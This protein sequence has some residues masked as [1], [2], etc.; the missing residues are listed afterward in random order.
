VAV[1]QSLAAPRMVAVREDHFSSAYVRLHQPT[2][3]NL[4]P[5]LFLSGDIH[6]DRHSASAYACISAIPASTPFVQSVFIRVHPW[7]KNLRKSRVANRMQAVANQ[8]I[9]P[10][11]AK[12][13]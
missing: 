3:A 4:A 13:P 5:P 6:K 1:T 8:K 12:L 7:L 10:I 9:Y 2:S 11:Y